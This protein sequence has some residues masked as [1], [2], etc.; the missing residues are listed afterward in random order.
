MGEVLEARRRV[1]HY[2]E[3]H[4]GYIP[5]HLLTTFYAHIDMERLQEAVC[6]RHMLHRTDRFAF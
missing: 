3:A 2:E 1:G 5:T 6:P 4:V